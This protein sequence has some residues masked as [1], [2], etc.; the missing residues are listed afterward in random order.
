MVTEETVT[1]QFI[2]AGGSWLGKLNAL[3][4]IGW[5]YRWLIGNIK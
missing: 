1:T 4:F 2:G 5:V 3:G